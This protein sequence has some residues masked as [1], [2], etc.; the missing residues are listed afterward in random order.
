MHDL[1]VDRVKLSLV[2]KLLN[3]V[4]VL[5]I[6]ITTNYQGLEQLSPVCDTAIEMFHLLPDLV[7]I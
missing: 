3:L 1:P 6:F 4:Q 7:S 2:H 5:I